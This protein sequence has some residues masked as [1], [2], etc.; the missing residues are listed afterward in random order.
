[1]LQAP[2]AVKPHGEQVKLSLS[3]IKSDDRRE[4]VWSKKSLGKFSFNFE[5]TYIDIS[6][7]KITKRN[8]RSVVRSPCSN[9]D[10]RTKKTLSKSGR[11]CQMAEGA[12]QEPCWANF[13]SEQKS[14][15]CLLP[16]H[17]DDWISWWRVSNNFKKLKTNETIR[18]TDIRHSTP[19]PG[20]APEQ[21]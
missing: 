1:M 11:F 18:L 14:S 5:S 17:S 12:E 8:W 15:L 13:Q 2:T 9:R 7:Q 21:R 4:K 3:M 16:Y 19:I 10:H 20:F 6:S